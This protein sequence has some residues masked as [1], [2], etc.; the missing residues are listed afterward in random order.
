MSDKAMTPSVVVRP[1]PL[2]DEEHHQLGVALRSSDVVTPWQVQIS[3][4]GFY[5]GPYT[6]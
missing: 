2:P 1:L 6:A 5:G 4:A 3:L